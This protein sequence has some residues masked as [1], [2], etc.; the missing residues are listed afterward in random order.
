[1]EM[2]MFMG[3]EI[4][5]SLEVKLCP[6]YLQVNKLSVYFDAPWLSIR[7]WEYLD[8][9]NGAEKRLHGSQNM[10]KNGKIWFLLCYWL[11]PL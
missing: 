7:N 2:D 9:C 11:N 8:K 5:W 10:G 6:S 3:E 4:M 1:M